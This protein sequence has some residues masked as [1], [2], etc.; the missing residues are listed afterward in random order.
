V[1]I[2]LSASDSRQL[3]LNTI[4]PTG[5]HE[6]YRNPPIPSAGLHLNI[7]G[8]LSKV[9]SVPDAEEVAFDN[10]FLEKSHDGEL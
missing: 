1:C 9:S 2:F 10:E 7:F 5:S 3:L 4:E 8:N 6:A